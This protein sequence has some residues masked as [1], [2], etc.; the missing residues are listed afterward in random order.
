MTDMILLKK[1]ANRRLYD[2]QKSAYVTLGE[3][4]DLIREGKTVKA[5]DAKT[6]AAC[7]DLFEH[8]LKILHPFMPFVTEELWQNI[9][10]RKD[11]DTI[12]LLDFPKAREVNEKLLKD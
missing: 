8:N 12:M 1:Y 4:A 11:G 9:E 5:F 6:K 3:V 10:E 7:I 2:T